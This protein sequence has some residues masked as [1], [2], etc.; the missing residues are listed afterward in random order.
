MVCLKD[1]GRGI[2]SYRNAVLEVHRGDTSACLY[3]AAVV[4][5]NSLIQLPRMDKGDVTETVQPFI[6]AVALEHFGGKRILRVTIA[7]QCGKLDLTTSSLN[8]CLNRQ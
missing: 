8:W 6:I 2:T 4:A 3:A 7:N 5:G 1:A